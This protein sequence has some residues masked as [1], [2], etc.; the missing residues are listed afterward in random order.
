MLMFDSRA[1]TLL[2]SIAARRNRS[3]SQIL[4]QSCMATAPLQ[5]KRSIAAVEFSVCGTE[6]GAPVRTFPDSSSRKSKDTCSTT[7]YAGQYQVL[8]LLCTRLKH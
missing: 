5:R 2:G 4:E 3:I 7:R 8:S 6:L 1:G